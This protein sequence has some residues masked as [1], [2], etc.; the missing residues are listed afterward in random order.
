[1]HWSFIGI[2]SSIH[3]CLSVWW[4][5]WC[6]LSQLSPLRPSHPNN[7]STKCWCKCSTAAPG[8]LFLWIYHSPLLHLVQFNHFQWNAI[9]EKYMVVNQTIKFHISWL[10]YF[11]LFVVKLIKTWYLMDMVETRWVKLSSLSLTKSITLWLMRK[12]DPL[13]INSHAQQLIIDN[14]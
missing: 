3:P 13:S 7:I 1:M 10:S 2:L 12:I 6:P 14:S 9:L 11:C 4:Q 5:R 8:S